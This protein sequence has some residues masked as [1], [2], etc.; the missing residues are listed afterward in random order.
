MWCFLNICSSVY[1]TLKVHCID[2]FVKQI[3]FRVKVQLII[4][5]K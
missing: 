3:L 4:M 5:V 1:V 2:S